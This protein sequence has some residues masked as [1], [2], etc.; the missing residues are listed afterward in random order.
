MKC[1][2]ETTL[3]NLIKVQCWR[4]I[5]I[6][7]L[8]ATVVSCHARPLFGRY[9]FGERAYEEPRMCG[10]CGDAEP[11]PVR[12]IVNTMNN[13]YSERLVCIDR[14]RTVCTSSLAA[15]DSFPYSHERY[16]SCRELCEMSWNFLQ[17]TLLF[18]ICYFSSAFF[19]YTLLSL[20]CLCP[21]VWCQIISGQNQSESAVGGHKARIL[22]S[23][24]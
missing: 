1:R 24:H 17:Q 6:A 21:A 5:S 23:L 2:D 12:V 19:V 3:A 15:E 22:F 10:V 20:C 9:R 13:I 8:D 16:K 7:A 11:R 4:H 14:P 18:W